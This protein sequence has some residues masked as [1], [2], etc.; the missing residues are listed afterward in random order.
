M[1]RLSK[2]NRAGLSL[3]QTYYDTQ[4]QTY[5]INEDP[6]L[7]W[8][9]INGLKDQTQIQSLLTNINV[10]KLWIEDIFYPNQRTKIETHNNSMYMVVNGTSQNHPKDISRY[11]QV[12]CR[13]NQIITISETPTD[14]FNQ[15]KSRLEDD[16]DSS[17]DRDHFLYLL[18][19][20]LVDFYLETELHLASAL[21]ELEQRFLEEEDQ[22][23][24]TLHTLRKESYTLKILA[25]TLVDPSVQKT[26]KQYLNPPESLTQQ[27]EDVFDHIHRLNMLLSEDREMVRNIVDL[28][29]NYMANRM[30]EIMKTLTI[31]S[32]I[33]IPLSFF[34][35]VFG[36]NF[37]DMPILTVQNAL[38]WFFAFSGFIA[39]IMIL[40]F[41]L[42]DW[43]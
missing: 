25:Q 23:I 39:I 36:M 43:I 30:N 29:N 13:N 18:L 20:H 11:I 2:L 27:Y 4:I 37:I 41:K 42:R 1:R 7:E 26:L 12:I 3:H 33:F 24:T 6:G 14:M 8:I 22:S 10:D 34:A 28:Y 40:F 5:V 38:P 16:T 31:F 21:L 19:D 32:A 35:G 15:L 17:L 9:S